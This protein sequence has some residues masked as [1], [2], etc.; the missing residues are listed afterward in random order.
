MFLSFLLFGFYG[1][2]SSQLASQLDSIQSNKAQSVDFELLES[3]EMQLNM[4]EQS[5][6][7]NLPKITT[8]TTAAATTITTTTKT[9]TTTTTT[10][11]ASITTTTF[12]ETIEKRV[13]KVE[14]FCKV[15]TNP[16]QTIR[17]LLVLKERNLVWCPVYKSGS[18]AWMKILVHLS[19]KS[20]EHKQRLLT[21]NPSLGNFT[22]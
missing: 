9:A 20:P 12:L 1:F 16:G 8:K 11:T 3:L 5:T 2:I 21:K 19:N 18:S 22:F 15:K 17:N 6:F 7:P 10:T 4:V 13:K 14:E